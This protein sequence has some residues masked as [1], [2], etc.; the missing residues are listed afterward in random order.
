MSA[1]LAILIGAGVVILVAALAYVVWRWGGKKSAITGAALTVSTFV[2]GFIKSFLKDDV[3][4]VD[5]YDFVAAGEVLASKLSDI[6]KRHNEGVS[7]LDTKADMIEAV[8][9]MVAKFPELDG[10]LSDEVIEK[11]V[12]AA[13]VLISNIPKVKDII[14]K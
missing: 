9:E 11:E 14:K 12:E 5:P 6:L 7:F 10:K 13:L 8:K 1:W 2:L 4:K 3:D